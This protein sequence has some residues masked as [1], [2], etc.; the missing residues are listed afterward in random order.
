MLI[1][2]TRFG[3]IEVKDESIVHM[4]EGMLGFEHCNRYALIEDRPDA[5]FKWLQAVD[6]PAVAFIVINPVE[7]FSEYEVE[8]TDEQAESLGLADATDSAMFTTVTVRR[9]E[10][11]ATTDLAGPIVMNVRT[12]QARQIVIEHD[13]YHT[14]HI[15]GEKAAC[16]EEPEFATAV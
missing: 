6:D 3:T 13:R 2:T 14:S 8:L 12:M 16:A 9:E 4:A 10:G 7:F 15:I 11:K 5:S 1:E